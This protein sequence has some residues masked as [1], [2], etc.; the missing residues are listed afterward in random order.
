VAD[1]PGPTRDAS[2]PE[3]SKPGT[4]AVGSIGQQVDEVVHSAEV[5]EWSELGVGDSHD[6]VAPSLE[7]GDTWA[8]RFVRRAVAHIGAEAIAL[9][10]HHRKPPTT[11]GSE[12]SLHAGS[13]SGYEHECRT[14][15]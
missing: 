4:E 14:F 2:R 6:L 15:S 10:A 1:H 13:V 8:D 11:I 12:L 5:I 3:V 7:N 9:T